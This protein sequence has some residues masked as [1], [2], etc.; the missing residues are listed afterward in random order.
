MMFTKGETFRPGIKINCLQ[1]VK[2][3]REEVFVRSTWI[4]S[5]S[6]SVDRAEIAKN[7]FLR[8]PSS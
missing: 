8:Q 4:H 6:K 2:I 3:V 7:C 1:V 5:A